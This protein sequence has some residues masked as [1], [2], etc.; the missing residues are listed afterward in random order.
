MTP[1]APPPQMLRLFVAIELP[2][3]VRRALAESM[4]MLQDALRTDILRWVRPEGMHLTLAFLGAVARDRVPGIDQALAAAARTR[5]AFTL[6][7]DGLGSFGG[8]T[9]VRVVWVGLAGDTAALADLAAAVAGALAPLGFPPEQRPF[10]AHLT[11]A[12]VRDDAA[13]DERE[14]LHDALSRTGAPEFPLMRA[15]DVSLMQSTLNRGG[16]IYHRLFGYP[17]SEGR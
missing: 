2:E 10:N 7:P 1:A 16:A 9:R 12:R 8:R 3:D 5:R 17:L 4:A 14:R 6:Q 13:R 15:T 11:L